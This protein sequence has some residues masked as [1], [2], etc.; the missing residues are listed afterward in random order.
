MLLLGNHF[1]HLISR[2]RVESTVDAHT[3]FGAGPVFLT[4]PEIMPLA[5]P[6]F[7]PNLRRNTPL[8]VRVVKNGFQNCSI[9][10]QAG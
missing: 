6:P 1:D 10:Y 3:I 9:D 5:I 7:Y 4:E 2:T 8:G